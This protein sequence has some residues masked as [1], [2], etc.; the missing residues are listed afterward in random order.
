M[1][2]AATTTGTA[3]RPAGI[4]VNFTVERETKGTFR[5]AE[6]GDDPIVGTLYLRKSACTKLGNPERLKLTINAS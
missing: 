1:A 5:Y 3:K 2:T 4:T 6:D